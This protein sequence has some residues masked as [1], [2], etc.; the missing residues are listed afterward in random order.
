LPSVDSN[1]TLFGS[2]QPSPL[3]FRKPSEK[4]RILELEKA[5]F[6]EK[7]KNQ[8]LNK[9]MTPEKL[10][11]MIHKW[12]SCHVNRLSKQLIQY[13]P[14]VKEMNILSKEAGA[15]QVFE[16]CVLDPEFNV[17]SIW[18][19]HFYAN[20]S[21]TIEL[22]IQVI[23]LERR[24]T[25]RWTLS[26]FMDRVSRIRCAYYGLDKNLLIPALDSSSI[27]PLFTDLPENI[28]A[29][30]HFATG[31]LSVQF[32]YEEHPT[33]HTLTL[34]SNKSHPIGCLELNVKRHFF[35]SSE[36]DLFFEISLK[37]AS[38]QPIVKTFHIECRIL[39]NAEQTS[40][41]LTEE[42]PWNDE[43]ILD[44][45]QIFRIPKKDVFQVNVLKF[46]CFTHQSDL[47]SWTPDMHLNQPVTPVLRR[48]TYQRV[49][50]MVMEVRML[51][52]SGA[53][54]T[55]HETSVEWNNDTAIFLLR[56]GLQRRLKLGIM[57][58]G[59]HFKR[60]TVLKVQLGNI[61]PRQ[62]KHGD[63]KYLDLL[64][65]EVN[66]L[67]E[68]R[69]CCSFELNWD[70]SR[71]E[72]I[73]LNKSFT[74]LQKLR[75]EFVLLD[76]MVVFSVHYD[77]GHCGTVSIKQSFGVYMFERDAKVKTMVKAQL[78]GLYMDPKN[79]FRIRYSDRWSL[80]LQLQSQKSTKRKS[81]TGIIQDDYVRGEDVLDG[82]RMRGLP[83]V[84]EY[85]K[86][87]ERLTL[88][89]DLLRTHR[90]LSEWK[91]QGSVGDDQESLLK[92]VLNL[93]TCK[94]APIIMTSGVV[95][96]L[97]IQVE[98]IQRK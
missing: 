32:L 28:P 58:T 33:D 84:F 64:T 79:F 48:K 71:H 25:H 96:E 2:G 6:E 18:D 4:N 73:L 77:N 27:L 29:F 62:E 97:D 3:L 13:W 37:K 14:L 59:G 91:G 95:P 23:D 85:Q 86:R 89:L 70:S 67:N 16:F 9:G 75:G 68:D 31:F 46:H 11:K 43:C 5:L 51:E 88:H 72:H 66:P 45:S 83:L 87:K 92:K 22:G 69:Y 81:L 8:V 53:T 42:Q 98:Y 15:P 39:P 94:R 40:T 21:S 19:D 35:V 76:L 41:L 56:Q 61:R 7:K 12:R 90:Q 36:E 63:G 82:W 26:T 1:S 38:F 65:S 44:H 54:G 52:L 34:L 24:H 20:F 78:L 93:L 57:D 30:E 50:L 47:F 60:C 74:T 10:K 17:Y 80:L 49:S 55:F